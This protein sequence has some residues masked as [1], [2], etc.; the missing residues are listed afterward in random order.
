MNKNRR[1][2]RE[3]KDAQG[4]DRRHQDVLKSLSPHDDAVTAKC[5][6]PSPLRSR[7]N[8]A[9]PARPSV[10][11]VK[12]SH[13]APLVAKGFFEQCQKQRSMNP[14]PHEIVPEALRKPAQPASPI[15]GSLDARPFLGRR[16]AKSLPNRG[17]NGGLGRCLPVPSLSDF[18]V[19]GCSSNEAFCRCVGIKRSHDCAPGGQNPFRSGAGPSRSRAD[20]ARRRSRSERRRPCT[21]QRSRQSAPLFERHTSDRRK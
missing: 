5:P 10:C 12:A 19:Y 16:P 17:S 21:L 11:A 13:L 4:R 2:A 1:A 6:P 7:G 3:A 9:L 14:A 18:V 8:C 20:P 15:P